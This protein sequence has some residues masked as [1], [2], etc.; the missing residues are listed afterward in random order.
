LWH[1]RPGALRTR[2]L[3]V[4]ATVSALLSIIILGLASGAVYGMSGV[5]LVLTYRTSNVFNFAYGAVGT[6]A[7][8]V[9]YSLNVNDHVAWPFA[10][11]I[12]VVSVA[13]VGGV[14]FAG[15]ARSLSTAPLTIQ[16]AA[17][18]GVMLIIQS[19]CIIVYGDT[20]LIF[21]SFLPSK[22]V[23]F[24]GTQIGENQLIVFVIATILT[25]MLAFLL[26]R[27]RVGI[28]MRAVVEGSTLLS[29]SG[30]NAGMIRALAWI[31]GTAFAAIAGLLIAPSVDLNPEILTL[32]VV[33]AY[34]AAALGLFKNIGWTFAGGLAV[35]VVD[36]V[37]T[38]YGTSS[39]FLTALAPGVPFVILLLVLF[40]MPRGRLPRPRL[41]A[42]PGR[43]RP[44]KRLQLGIAVPVAAI[45]ILV[46]LFA[47]SRLGAY[48][49][50]A[51]ITVLFLSL[52][53]LVR[54]SG[55][56]SLGHIGLAAIGAAAFGHMAGHGVPWGVAVVLS[57]LIVVPF[58]A[59]LAIPAIRHG[60]LY[61][62]LATFGFGLVLQET[63]YS[64]SIMFGSASVGLTAPL[65]GGDVLLTNT[66]Y[67][68]ILG[69]V[70]VIALFV[71]L[72]LSGRLGRLLNAFAQSPV[73]LITSGL[74]TTSFQVSIFCFA[75]FLAGIGGALFASTLGLATGASFDP[76][77][78][79]V[80]VAV[81][82]ISAG[83]F[84]WYSVIAAMAV[85]LVPNYISG[86]NTSSYLNIL[87]GVFAVSV[88]V[89]PT[90]MQNAT[91]QRRLAGV[92]GR[93]R[94]PGR[95]SG[96]PVEEFIE[97]FDSSPQQAPALRVTQES[98]ELAAAGAGRGDTVE[99]VLEVRN[100]TV[101]FGGLVA[102]EHLDL[103]AK[104]GAITALIG[105]NG[106]GKT[107]TFN[108]CSAL[109]HLSSG[110]V[111]V[112][113]R[114]VTRLG[115]AHRARLGVGRT[116]QE[117]N[118]FEGMSVY[119]NIAVVSDAQDAGATPW[120]QMLPRWKAHRA[121][122][123]RVREVAAVCGLV[124]VL[125]QRAGLLSTAQRRRVDLAR[126]LMASPDVLLLDEPL[127][128]LD[129]SEGEA[130]MLL[131]ERLCTDYGN[132]ILVVEHDLDFV[133]KMARHVYVLDFG[134]LIF[135]GDPATVMESDVV[136]DAY[137]GNVSDELEATA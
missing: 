60:G 25:G 106:A 110:T 82:V 3:R 81:I 80:Y 62:A 117:M 64:K 112:K 120:R 101:R 92:K 9:F 137:T 31:V 49:G 19:I 94:I 15:L 23:H 102:V 114:D 42:E 83:S 21:P 125:D 95:A 107:T 75:A 118:L 65:P 8:Y 133:V 115:P 128:G 35:G 54:E 47:E 11:L 91:V 48:A 76:F 74:D 104:R 135:E 85:V 36:A 56:V 113:G 127:S 67:Y 123:A 26:K 61:L 136:R 37:I 41:V 111:H 28:S 97:A 4:R 46:P 132:A 30:G 121:I 93:I 72:L 1:G 24:L 2:E 51:A 89:V 10:V 27:T 69:I 103:R 130:L 57:G 134:R 20:T 122:E 99:D 116:F 71:T 39:S 53:L 22:S 34:A 29:L 59:L 55:Q 105:P 66:D 98:S 87:F 45:L 43:K 119:Q 5:G 16:V 12:A 100:L 90:L 7:A 14:L 63:L 6:M 126:A 86:A 84:P 58:G 96:A 73:A 13:L 33:Q 17:T 52:G 18:V 38:Y 131:L 70:A 50:G 88:A 78:S 108:A 129:V 109:T 68:I 79:L 77:T 44:G 40:V 124:G 32:L